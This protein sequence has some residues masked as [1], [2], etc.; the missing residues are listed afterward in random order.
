MEIFLGID[1]CVLN[2]V[3][4]GCHIEQRGMLRLP[5]SAAMMNDQLLCDGTGRLASKVFLSHSQGEVYSG[6][7]PSR[8]P[9]I[10]INNEDAIFFHLH[11]RIS[12][13][14]VAGAT[15]FPGDVSD[16]ASVRGIFP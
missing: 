16:G 7:H 1:Q 2:S 6:G 4:L 5:A 13:L 10:S 15:A 14:K 8:S 9:N 3:G 12:R 11:I